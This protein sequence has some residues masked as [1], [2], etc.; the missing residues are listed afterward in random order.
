MQR[1]DNLKY[2]D[3]LTTAESVKLKDKLVFAQE[4]VRPLPD[5]LH[6]QKWALL[7]PKSKFSSLQTAF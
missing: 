6:S 1:V 5:K 2:V 7:S 3:D 4:S